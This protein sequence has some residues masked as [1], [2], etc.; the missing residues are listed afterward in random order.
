VHFGLHP[1][2]EPTPVGPAAAGLE[3]PPVDVLGSSVEPVVLEAPSETLGVVGASVVLG[4][5]E[6]ALGVLAATVVEVTGGREEA[7]GATASARLRCASAR[8]RVRTVRSAVLVRAR[9]PRR[10]A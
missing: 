1:T 2:A 8:L 10:W 7:G 5:F 9:R 3:D 4:A 6:A